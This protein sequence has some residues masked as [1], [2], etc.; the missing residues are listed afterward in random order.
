MKLTRSQLKVFSA[1]F[2]DLGAAW[3]IAIFLTQNM[4]T[5]TYNIAA[6]ILSIYTS[7]KLEESIKDY[8]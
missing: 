5:L 7:I 8:D 6:A 3:I 1:V 4:V 2:S